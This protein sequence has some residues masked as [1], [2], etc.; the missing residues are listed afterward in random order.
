MEV[1][2]PRDFDTLPHYLPYTA[3]IYHDVVTIPSG[4]TN[5][6]LQEH[7]IS[8]HTYLAAQTSSN[9]FNGNLRVVRGHNDSYWFAGALWWYDRSHE[10]LESLR[11]DGP[12]TEEVT[13]QLLT[14]EDG[15]GVKI[16]FSVP[17]HSLHT[18]D[19]SKNEPFL[20]H[21]NYSTWGQCEA[22]CGEGVRRREVF[23]VMLGGDGSPMNSSYCDQDTVP[24]KVEACS[25]GSCHWET[26]NWT[27][28]GR[29]YTH[30]STIVCL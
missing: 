20:Y 4:S 19:L 7:K 30:T 1:Y 10:R 15:N 17:K 8:S 27:K 3:Y 29:Q 22:V 24:A 14:N 5:I 12:T 13:V 18:V 2:I 25:M 26:G 21:W 11:T 16:A 23:C 9:Q 28:V 6:Q